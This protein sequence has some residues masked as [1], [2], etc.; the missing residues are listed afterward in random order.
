MKGIYH[1]IVIFFVTFGCYYLNFYPS[2]G[3]EVDYQS[4]GYVAS[5][6][7]TFVVTLQ[8]RRLFCDCVVTYCFRSRWTPYCGLL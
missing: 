6:A 3:Y 7:L 2:E 4:F 1:A 5:G 8:V